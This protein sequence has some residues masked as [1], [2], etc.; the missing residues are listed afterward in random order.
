MHV[1][2]TSGGKRKFFLSMCENFSLSKSLS[3]DVKGGDLWSRLFLPPANEVAG[4]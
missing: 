3:Q 2:A 1:N 4:M